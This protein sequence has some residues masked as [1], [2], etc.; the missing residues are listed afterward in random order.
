MTQLRLPSLSR[1]FVILALVAFLMLPTLAASAGEQV[2]ITVA[3]GKVSLHVGDE[4]TVQVRVEDVTALYGA[5]IR[6]QFNP[7]HFAVVDASPGLPG[8]QV[9][10]ETELLTPDLIVRREANNQTGAIWYAVTQL[11]P[12]PPATGS[13]ALFSFKLRAKGGGS[14]LITFA[15][16]QLTT[17]DAELITVDLTSAAR[18]AITV[19][20]ETAYEYVFPL[21]L[22]R[23]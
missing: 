18:Y 10:P 5:D 19:A 14:G 6:L 20:G 22:R 7:S 13:G 16:E 4:V 3:P 15:Y 9:S 1:L 2:A 21:V 11:N 23:H 8:V 17:R 12:R